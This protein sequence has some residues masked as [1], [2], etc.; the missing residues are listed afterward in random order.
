MTKNTKYSSSA[1]LLMISLMTGGRF[2]YNTREKNIL[3]PQ[4][5]WCVIIF[6]QPTKRDHGRHF[7]RIGSFWRRASVKWRHEMPLFLYH[8][9][10]TQQN[11]HALENERN[12]VQEPI[13]LP[14]GV[15]CS[16][17]FPR[18]KRNTSAR[19][20]CSMNI[21]FFFIARR[22]LGTVR[23]ARFLGVFARRLSAT[24]LHLAP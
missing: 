19:V 15:R 10:R 23:S 11:Q 4:C 13:F 18:N 2:I 16:E 5:V 21:Y 20:A 3:G 7:Q 17:R 12:I 9:T 24:G 22:R 1:S 14:S 8:T 6:W